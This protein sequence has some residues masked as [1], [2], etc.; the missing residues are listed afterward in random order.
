M[1]PIVGALSI[2]LNEAESRFWRL[3]RL[4]LDPVRSPAVYATPVLSGDSRFFSLG[5]ISE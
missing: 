4:V 2:Y 3:E 5:M 1:V